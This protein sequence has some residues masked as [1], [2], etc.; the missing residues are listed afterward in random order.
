MSNFSQWFLV[1]NTTKPAFKGLLVIV[2]SMEHL[3]LNQSDILICGGYFILI[4]A[5]IKAVVLLVH[6]PQQFHVDL[7][8]PIAER[9]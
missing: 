1:K 9:R 2:K 3:M 6:E 8:L 7:E 4:I 5:S